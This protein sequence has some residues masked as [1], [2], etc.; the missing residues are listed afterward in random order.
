MR[1]HVVGTTCT[2]RR[3]CGS[4]QRLLGRKPLLGDHVVALIRAAG[5]ND[6]AR[7]EAL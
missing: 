3:N 1:V 6:V 2:T 4:S 5:N 7:L